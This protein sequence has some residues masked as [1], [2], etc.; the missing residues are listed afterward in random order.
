MAK[1]C[2]DKGYAYLGLTDH[3]QTA[4]Y[5][6]GLKLEDIL[7]QHQEIDKLNS[8]LAPFHI[9]KGIESDILAD[10][11]LDYPDEVLEKFDFVIASIHSGFNMAKEEMTERIKTALRNPFTTILAH[12]TGRLLLKRESYEVSLPEVLATAAEQG[13]A[14]ELNSNPKRLELDWRHIARAQSLGIQIPICPD[15][16]S[17]EGISNVTWGV[18][19]ARKGGLAPENIPN[20]W[21]LSEVKDWL[22][23]R[24]A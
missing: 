7:Q 23:S 17:I 4:S 2:I 9:F 8:K 5:A 18:V 3:S 1:G 20:A 12:P 16:H 14:V 11:S 15:A 22:A 6:G 19:A 10:G 21:S 24:R 13:V